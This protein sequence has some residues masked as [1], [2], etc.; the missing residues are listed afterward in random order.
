VRY[1]PDRH[2][3]R[4]VRL[5]EY[6]YSLG[7]SYFITICAHARECLFGEVVDGAMRSNAPGEI[8]R[9]EW[10]RSGDVRHEL[11][12]GAFAVMPNHVHGIVTIAD[13]RDAV[14]AHGHAPLHPTLH[15]PPR[16]IGSF[17]ARFK[18]AATR[19]INALRGTQ[20][21]MVWQRN[22]YEHIVR[23]EDDYD[24]IVA[25]IEDNPRRWADDE[26][27]PDR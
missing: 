15:R 3:R 26:Y 19:R 20:G 23:D 11:T 10:E 5:P 13:E 2:H 27:N 21:A 24:R 22:Y 8:V 25:Y 14:G 18:G 1:D 17:V 7:G 9:E 4:S 12:M 6:D 16:S